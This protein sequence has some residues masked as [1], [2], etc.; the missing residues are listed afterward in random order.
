MEQRME[1]FSVYHVQQHLRLQPRKTSPPPPGCLIRTWYC[2]VL[3]FSRPSGALPCIRSAA[4]CA[5]AQAFQRRRR[6]GADKINGSAPP[7]DAH[8]AMDL[9]LSSLPVFR[10]PTPYVLP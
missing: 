1:D 8:S 7:G 9:L 10:P 2:L 6:R 4:P 5:E 3:L